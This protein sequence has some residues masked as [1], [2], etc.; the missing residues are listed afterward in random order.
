MTRYLNGSGRCT[1][2]TGL[3]GR[4]AEWDQF[5]SP[6]LDDAVC[7]W[8]P[9]L[10]VKQRILLEPNLDPVSMIKMKSSLARQIVGFLPV[11]YT[12]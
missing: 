7:T 3:P 4:Q 6:Q 9:N 11:D 12:T 5:S 1:V 10:G 2:V 8:E